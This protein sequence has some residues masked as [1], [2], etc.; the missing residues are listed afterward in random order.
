MEERTIFQNKTEQKIKTI[1]PKMFRIILLNDDYTTMEFVVEI[2][3]TVF[4]K[5]ETE[6]TMIMLDVHKKGRGTVG[7]YTYDIAMTKKSRVEEIARK[8]EY[9]L[10]TIVEEA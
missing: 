3:M 2:L 8:R 5:S 4:R 1:K 9:P 10:K 7:V 6:A